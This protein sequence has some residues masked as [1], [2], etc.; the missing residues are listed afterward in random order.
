MFGIIPKEAESF[1]IPVIGLPCISTHCLTWVAV[2]SPF[3]WDSLKTSTASFNTVLINSPTSKASS[4]F[5]ISHSP[6]FLSIN[7]FI[8]PVL[9]PWPS[10]KAFLYF[11]NFLPL[12]FFRSDINSNACSLTSCNAN[13]FWPLLVPATKSAKEGNGPTPFPPDSPDANKSS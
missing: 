11:V 6:V 5:F 4:S 7:L 10:S 1:I 8:W 3:S 9:S 13:L 12:E 2:I